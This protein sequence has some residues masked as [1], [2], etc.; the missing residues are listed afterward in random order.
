M[1]PE[2]IE[3]GNNEAFIV[4]HTIDEVYTYGSSGLLETKFIEEIDE[5]WVECDE[6]GSRDVEMNF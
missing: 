5:E 6:C 3:C 4:R 2:C 1:P